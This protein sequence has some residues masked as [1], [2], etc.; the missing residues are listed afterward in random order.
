MLKVA[1]TG[2]IASG[3]SVVEEILKRKNFPVLDCDNAV[4]ELYKTDFI[5]KKVVEAFPDFDILEEGRLSRPK[6]GKIVFYD[7]TLRK[8]LEEIIYP[9]VKEEIGRFFRQNEGEKIAFVSVPLL[10][11]SGFE[12]LFDKIVLIYA[13][14]ETRIARLIKR[15]NLTPEQAQN[16]LNIQMSQDEKT[17]LAHYVILNNGNLDDL[18]F[19]VDKVLNYLDKNSTMP[20]SK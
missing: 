18:S 16:R 12:S 9:I 11:E 10:F 19:E 3:K 14:D 5:K 2:N 20:E 8:K 4:H 6:L 17:K 7:S 15:N 1:I 13:D